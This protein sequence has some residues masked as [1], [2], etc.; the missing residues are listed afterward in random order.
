MHELIRRFI[1]TLGASIHMIILELIVVRA[2]TVHCSINLNL[3]GSVLMAPG[4]LQTKC[5]KPPC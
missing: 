1:R 2:C 5:C 4:T 3:D